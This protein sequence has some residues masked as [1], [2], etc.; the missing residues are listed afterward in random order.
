MS[1]WQVNVGGQARE[2]RMESP[3]LGRKVIFVDG[4]ELKKVGTPF[5]MW[6]SY[7]L[8]LDGTPAVIKFRAM[9]RLKG[10]SLFVDGERV[11]PKPGGHTSAETI[12]MFQ[13][14]VAVA[15][16]GFLIYAITTSG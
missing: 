15:L 7:R 13:L 11:E 16:V 3:A 1:T 9:K 5:S 12:Q 10:M 4:V 6:S 2:V 14:L 8:D